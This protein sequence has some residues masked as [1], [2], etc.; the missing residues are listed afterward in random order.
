MT[1][2]VFRKVEI[3][4]VD[5]RSLLRRSL[6]FDSLLTARTMAGLM[7]FFDDEL[8]HLLG[9]KGQHCC[10]TACNDMREISR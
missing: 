3:H 8:A 9:V 4:L 10:L 2:V 1:F 7:S 5:W 6:Q